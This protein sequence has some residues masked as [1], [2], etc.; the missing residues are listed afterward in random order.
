MEDLCYKIF[1]NILQCLTGVFL[2]FDKKTLIKTKK[3]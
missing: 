1:N 3:L 2:L